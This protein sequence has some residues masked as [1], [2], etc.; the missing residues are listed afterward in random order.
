M[1]YSKDVCQFYC[2]LMKDICRG[3]RPLELQLDQLS[4]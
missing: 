1:R 3:Y 2:L 4:F